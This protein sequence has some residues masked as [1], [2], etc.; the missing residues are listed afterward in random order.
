M[1][2]RRSDER[3][4]RAFWDSGLLLPS[5]TTIIGSVSAK[6]GIPYWHGTEAAR[7]AVERHDEIADL[8]AQGEEKRAIALIAGAPRR[9]TA[10]ASELG[11]LF[12]RVADAKIRNRNL[13]LTEDEAEAVAPFE[14][15]LDRF[16]EEMQPTYRWTEATLYNRRLLYAGTGD[17]GLELGVSLPVVMRRRLVHTFP[18]GELLIG[19]YK[20]GNAVYDETGAQLTGY[21]SCSHMSLRD[22]TNTI[23]EMPRVAGGVVIHIRPDGY[24]AHG[25]LITP[26]MRAGWEYARRWFEVQREVVSGSVGLGVRAGG[27]RVDDFTSIDIRVRNA[28]ALRGVSTLADLEAFGPEKLLAIKHAGPATVGTAREILAIEGREWPLGPDETTETTQERGAA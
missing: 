23:V 9:I 7:Y 10:E 16:I 19:D 1:G 13:P 4:Y 20:S 14:A 15:T 3:W 22:A 5:V 17:C 12:H 24:R 26:E 11:K 21:A 18:P 27:F 2:G 6:G 25:V 8:I 28:L